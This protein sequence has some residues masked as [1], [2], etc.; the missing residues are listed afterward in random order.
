MKRITPIVLLILLAFTFFTIV[1]LAKE[2]ESQKLQNPSHIQ[3]TEPGPGPETFPK[4]VL[5]QA[6]PVRPTQEDFKREVLD[7]KGWTPDGVDNIKGQ[8]VPAGNLEVAEKEAVPTLCTIGNAKTGGYYT[9]GG[10]P[11]LYCWGDIVTATLMN[12]EDSATAVAMCPQ[13]IYPFLAKQVTMAIYTNDTATVVFQPEIREALF[14]ASG[15][16]YPGNVLLTGPVYSRLLLPGI[17]Q[18]YLSLVDSVCLYKPWFAVMHFLNSDDFQDT[19]Y[20]TPINTSALFSWVFDNSGRTC[21]SYWNPFGPGGSWYDVVLYAIESGAIR[22]RTR[23]Y[24]KPENTCLPPADTWYFKDSLASAPCGVPDFDQYQMPGPAYCGPTAG[25]NSVWWFSARG[26]FQPSWGGLDSA[27]VQ[28]LINQIAV[29]AGTNPNN[30]TECDS[31]GSAILAVI[32]SNGGWWFTETTVYKPDFWYLQKELKASE[33]VILLLGFWQLDGSTWT[34]FGGHFVTLAGVDIYNYKFAF[35]DPALDN[36]ENGMPGTVCHDSLIPY[37]HPGQPLVH[38]NTSNASHDYY[39]AAWPSTSP[40]GYVYLPDYTVTWANFQNQNFRTVHKSY[41]A[42]YNPALPVTVEIEQAIAISPGA[43]GMQGEV[44]SSKAYEINNNSGGLDAFGV[45]FGSN[46]VSGLYKGSI[47]AGTSQSDLNNDYGSYSPARTFNPSSPPA[48]DSFTVTGAAGDYKI[49]QLTNRFEQKFIPGLDITEYAFGFWV[50]VGGVGDC[51]YVVED[52]FI[53]DNTNAL[54]VSGLQ[55]A[56]LLDYDIGVN[57]ACKVDFDQ[58]HRSMWMWDQSG[59]DT[60]FGVTKIPAV[61]GDRAVTGW[62]ISNPARIYNGQYLDSLKYW[63]GN[64]GWGSDNPTVFEDKSILLADSSFNLATSTMRIEKWL[65]WGYRTPIGANGDL[66]WRQFLYNVLHQQG[67]YRGDVNKDRKLDLA[68]IVYLVAYVFKRG[69][70][71]KEFTDQGD[72]NNNGRVNVADVV[73]LVAYT[74]KGGPAP[75]DK[76]RFLVNSPFVDT[77]HKSLAVR[78]PGLFG[79]PYWWNLGR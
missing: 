49:Y 4:V 54:E 45:T 74:F 58:V 2:R 72:V 19:T 22:I 25:A 13:P 12:P 53:F 75:I 35:S 48:L 51:E 3:K 10:N 8:P 15:C 61:I 68:D 18:T 50:P 39:N 55:T 79:D 41:K 44:Q 34:R 64:L 17:D 11:Y 67:Y 31:L 7:R 57:N 29:A 77:P 47:I 38:D 27:H 24:S 1:P 37:P 21:Q 23:G 26:D 69:P 60:I 6:Q 43:K 63:M 28:N 52:A 59:T 16:A 33:D 73:Y 56:I 20:C 9:P 76:N 40:G 65:K 78:N 30:G 32:K 42:T 70:M 71:P 62:G 36:A 46:I 5:P 14:D 66:A